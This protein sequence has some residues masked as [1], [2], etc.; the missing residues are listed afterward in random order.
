MKGRTSFV[1]A[2]RLSNHK[3][4]DVILVMKDGSIMGTGKKNHEEPIKKR[5][6]YEDLVQS[7][8]FIHFIKRMPE[9]IG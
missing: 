3:N 5:G 1:V 2:H 8:K 7:C 6:F 4:A 9:G